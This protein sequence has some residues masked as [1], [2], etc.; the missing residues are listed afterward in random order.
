MVSAFINDRLQLHDSWQLNFE[1]LDSDR[2]LE[3]V[4]QNTTPSM[5][6]VSL[7]RQRVGKISR[8]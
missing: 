7:V 8:Q 3:T 5:R 6:Q 2:A 1:Y 4:S